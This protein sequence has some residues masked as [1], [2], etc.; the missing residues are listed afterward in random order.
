MPGS[1]GPQRTRDSGWQNSY[2]NGFSNLILHLRI[3]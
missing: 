3:P 1:F 2:L